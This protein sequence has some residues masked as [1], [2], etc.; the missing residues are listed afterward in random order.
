VSSIP[1]DELVNLDVTLAKHIAPRVL[2][3]IGACDSYPENTS[4]EAYKADLHEIA[5]TFERLAEELDTNN[6]VDHDRIAA[7]LD[8]FAK[9]YRSLWI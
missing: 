6:A 2:A 3:F 7:G 4:L 8:L 1:R 9:H 5:W